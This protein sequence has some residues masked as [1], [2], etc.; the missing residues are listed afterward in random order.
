MAWQNDIATATGVVQQ[1]LL[2]CRIFTFQSLYLAAP[3]H[4]AWQCFP[5]APRVLAQPKWLETKIKLAHV[6][7]RN[8]LKNIKS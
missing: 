3:V 5:I 7:F 1:A 4:V 2:S 8:K 6:I